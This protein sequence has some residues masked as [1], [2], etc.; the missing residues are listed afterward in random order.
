MKKNEKSLKFVL[1]YNFAKNFA[2]KKKNH[3]GGNFSQVM[4]KI[5]NERENLNRF[6][7]V[8]LRTI[9]QIFNT[10]SSG[11]KMGGRRGEGELNTYIAICSIHTIQALREEGAKVC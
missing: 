1:C 3:V 5:S 9:F 2:R 4:R 7:P 6:L 8:L 11:E 10:I